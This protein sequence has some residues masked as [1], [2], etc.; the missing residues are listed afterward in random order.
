[1]SYIG[2]VMEVEGEVLLDTFYKGHKYSLQFML[3]TA[4]QRNRY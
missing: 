3:L 4:Q 1:M 2:N